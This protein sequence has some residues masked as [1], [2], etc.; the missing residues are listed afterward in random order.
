MIGSDSAGKTT[1][2]NRLMAAFPLSMKYL[3]MGMNP[4]S[5]NF[6]LPTSRFIFKL[7]LA[8]LQKQTNVSNICEHSAVSLHRLEHRQDGRVKIGAAARLLNRL[9]EEVFRQCV[10][11][12][13]QFR[14]YIVIYDRQ[15]LFDF[16]TSN[17]RELDYSSRVSSRIHL[18]F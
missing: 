11:W 17:S 5:S 15:F 10:S 13:Y 4:Q 12:T 9:S 2:A 7:R 6:A 1:I 8:K 3:Y 14:G 16:S 18:W